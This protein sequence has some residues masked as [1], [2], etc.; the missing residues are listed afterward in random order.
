MRRKAV[1][2]EEALEGLTGIGFSFQSKITSKAIDGG[3]WITS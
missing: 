2:G 1:G 3:R